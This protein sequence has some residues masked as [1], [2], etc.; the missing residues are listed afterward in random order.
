MNPVYVD[1]LAVCNYSIDGEE[2]SF[3]AIN[4]GLAE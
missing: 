4:R 1:G 3:S 2:D